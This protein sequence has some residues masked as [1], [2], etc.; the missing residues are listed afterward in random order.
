MPGPPQRLGWGLQAQPR[1]RRDQL[2]TGRVD[3]GQL[4]TVLGASD[5]RSGLQ[6]VNAGP[7][8]V[9]VSHTR[10]DLLAVP[11]K[12]LRI[13]ADLTPVDVPSRATLYG[14]SIYSV[15][16]MRILFSHYASQTQTVEI[17]A[18]DEVA[19][20]ETLTLSAWVL[21]PA[22]V[23]FWFAP[24]A[25]STDL[26]GSWPANSYTRLVGTGTWQLIT[27]TVTAASFSTVPTSSYRPGVLIASNTGYTFTQGNHLYDD[28]PNGWNA[29]PVF[30]DYV[31]IQLSGGAQLIADPGFDSGDTANIKISSGQTLGLANSEFPD[32]RGGGDT[33]PLRWTCVLDSP[34]NTDTDNLPGAGGSFVSGGLL[35]MPAPGATHSRQVW[36]EMV[37]AIPSQTWSYAVQWINPAGITNGLMWI[38][39]YNSSGASIADIVTLVDNTTGTRTYSGSVT[40]PANTAFIRWRLHNHQNTSGTI[41]VD[42]AR[43]SLPPTAPTPTAVIAGKD[44]FRGSSTL[45]YAETVSE[46]Y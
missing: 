2:R 15:N 29:G 42:Y 9:L 41:Q 21:A 31:S 16:S 24:A 12:G 44:G 5:W 28:N 40:T 34:F 36:S 22:G 23:P 26:T 18:L 30:V 11:P 43:L 45:T 35:S 32:D 4:T 17:L 8:P 37:R 14:T 19:A 25:R 39:A 1:G 27:A 3:V 13:P 33:R 20:D 10:D 7:A 6:L 38:T 46:E